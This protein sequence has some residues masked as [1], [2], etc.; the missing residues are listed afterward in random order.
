M[1][2]DPELVPNDGEEPQVVAT[3]DLEHVTPD[4]GKIVLGVK[5]GGRLLH[6]D[7]HV[8]PLEDGSLRLP[9]GR[10]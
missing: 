2:H 9:E 4:L 7:R 10:V 3:Q 8:P 1:L 6:A 5:C